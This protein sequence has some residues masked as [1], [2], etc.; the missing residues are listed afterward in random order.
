M[1][2]REQLLRRRGRFCFLGGECRPSAAI[3]PVQLFCGKEEFF[4]HAVLRVEFQKLSVQEGIE[5]AQVRA[6][7]VGR[8]SVAFNMEAGETVDT[9]SDFILGAP[10]SLQMMTAAMKL[11]DTYS[12]EGKLWPT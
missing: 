4:H 12:L 9:V 6:H 1:I 8:Q 7:A 2:A 11:K 5:P 10:K 3:E